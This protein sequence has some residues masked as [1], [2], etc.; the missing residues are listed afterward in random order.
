[1]CANDLSIVCFSAAPPSVSVSC[2]NS[3]DGVPTVL[4]TSER[5]YPAD[6]TQAWLRDGK[7]INYLN[8]SLILPNT[9]NL[10]YSNFIWNYR[11]NTD[12]SYSVTS[13]LHLSSD[14][15]VFYCRVN[16]S[17]LTKPITVNISSTECTDRGGDDT[18]A[19]IEIF[20]VRFDYTILWWC[21][22]YVI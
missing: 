15:A 17:T 19:G 16:H 18:P 7:Y 2:V 13:Y 11:K 3:S 22:L 9:E 4:C 6:L 21:L 1:M 20:G 10:N 5:F 12:G 8:T 14:R